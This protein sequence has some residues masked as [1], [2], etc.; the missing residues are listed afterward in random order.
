MN[1][2]GFARNREKKRVILV[3][4]NDD[5]MTDEFFFKYQGADIID[6]RQPEQKAKLLDNLRAWANQ[7]NEPHS[8]TATQKPSTESVKKQAA[9]SL[10]T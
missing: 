4:I 8:P 5:S 1:E 10:V 2:I 3:R 9:D 6:W 7:V